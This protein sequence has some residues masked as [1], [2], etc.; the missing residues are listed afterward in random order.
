MTE[1]EIGGFDTLGLNENVLRAVHEVGYEQPTQVQRETIPLL[2]A[3]RDVI[4]QSQTGTGKT[5]A[6]ALPMI[7]KVSAQSREVQGLVLVPT[8]E[9]AVQVASTIHK[10][11]KYLGIS[12]LPIYG[13]Q[14]IDR[15][16]RALRQG[17]QIVVGTPGRIMDHMRRG[18]LD[19]SHVKMI[20][21]D[22]ADQML[23]MGFIED[24]EVILDDLPENV[25]I[26]LFSATIPPR[27]RQ[28]ADRYLKNPAIISVERQQVTVPEVRQFYAEVTRQA[29]VEA[30]TRILDMEAPESAM[31]F[32]RTKSQ[33]DDLGETLIGRGYLAEVIHGDLSQAQRERALAGFRSGKAEILVATDVASRGLD[34]PN[35]GL[36]LN[37]DIPLDPEAYVHR[38]GR[39]ARAGKEGTAITF[40]TPRERGLL[41]T[42]ERLI[43]MRIARMQIPTAADVAERR[44]QLFRSSLRDAIAGDHLEPYMLMVEELGE[45]FDLS[46]IAAGAIKLAYEEELVE[47]VPPEAPVGEQGMERLFVRAGRNQGVTAGDLV[48]AIANEANISGRDIGA[49]EVQNNFSFVDVPRSDAH[50]VIDALLRSGVRGKRVKVNI[51]EPAN[52]GRMR[53]RTPA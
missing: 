30:L 49:I 43:N 11:G 32:V 27:I 3:G 45:E 1:T 36:V 20:I 41:R 21:L 15:Q 22:E 17:V 46:A 37:Y 50:R 38:I 6:F 5:A 29:K 9:L 24:I 52:A 35:V 53:P 12:D 2:L 51:A 42:I 39:T 13:G 25:Q 44:S 10:L 23:D 34:I 28:L 7:E 16:L 4:G 47:T 14:P 48:G 8:R 18:S 33:T 19:L 40:V 31:I 26:G